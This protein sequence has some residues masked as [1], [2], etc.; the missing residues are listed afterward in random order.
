V[1]IPRF[2]REGCTGSM[3]AASFLLI[4]PYRGT[5]LFIVFYA[6]FPA[7]RNPV[8]TGPVVTRVHQTM[9]KNACIGGMSGS[10][11]KRGAFPKIH[12]PPYPNIIG[13]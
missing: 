12:Y 9:V 2:F 4:I 13:I 8:V 3:G 7:C 6:R 11:H 10:F 5:A 1:L